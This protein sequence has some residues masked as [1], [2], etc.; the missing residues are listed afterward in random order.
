[1]STYGRRAPGMTYIYCWACEADTDLDLD[2]CPE[3]LD[4]KHEPTWAGKTS[5]QASS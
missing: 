5:G 4:G 2:T 3:S 1:M